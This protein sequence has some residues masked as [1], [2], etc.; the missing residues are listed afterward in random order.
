MKFKKI[1]LFVLLFVFI[2]SGCTGDFPE[3]V[4]KELANVELK[5]PKQGAGKL[6]YDKNCN[7]WVGTKP[8]EIA[9]IYFALSSFHYNNIPQFER[10]DN[11]T[12][13][14]YS[15]FKNKVI[16]QGIDVS[17]NTDYFLEAHFPSKHDWNT[18]GQRG[19][20]LYNPPS[21]FGVLTKLGG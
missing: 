19:D 16:I 13:K 2:W 14:Y 8:S 18:F 5:E 3:S 9:N 20:L 10:G 4:K 6:V 11:L 15:T 21:D 17:R 12:V 7:C 1:P